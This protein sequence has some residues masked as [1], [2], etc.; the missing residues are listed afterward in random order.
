MHSLAPSALLLLRMRKA[1]IPIEEFLEET[2][3]RP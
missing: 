2:G 1:S 3:A